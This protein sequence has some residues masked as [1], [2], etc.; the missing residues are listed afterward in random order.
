MYEEEGVGTGLDRPVHVALHDADVL[1]SLGDRSRGEKMELAVGHPRSGGVD[2]G[3]VGGQDHLVDVTLLARELA[4]HRH[5]PGDVRGIETGR[6][7]AAVNQQQIPLFEGI[8]V[9]GVVKDIA[10][11]RHDRVEGLLSIACGGRGRV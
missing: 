1:E 11:H 10:T 8:F 6:L 3:L 9:A 7:G 4:R 5:R 2:R